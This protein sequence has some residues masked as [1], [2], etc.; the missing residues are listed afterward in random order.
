MKETA[1]EWFAEKVGHNSLISLVEYNEL[2]EQ[3]KEMEKKQIVDARINGDVNG[4]CIFKIARREAEQYYNK[5][6]KSE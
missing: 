4:A 3:A 6:F 1:V 2:F 5:T